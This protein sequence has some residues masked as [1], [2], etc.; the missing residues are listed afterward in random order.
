MQEFHL[1]MQLA[2]FRQY[3]KDRQDEIN[4]VLDLIAKILKALEGTI[5]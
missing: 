4:A 3:L 5:N 1:R 2:A